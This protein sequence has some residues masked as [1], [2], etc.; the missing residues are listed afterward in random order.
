[1]L[2]GNANTCKY[3]AIQPAAIA[4]SI[5]GNVFPQLLVHN[6]PNGSHNNINGVLITLTSLRMNVSDWSFVLCEILTRVVITVY[7]FITISILNQTHHWEH[8]INIRTQGI[9]TRLI[10]SITWS[11][12]AVSGCSAQTSILSALFLCFMAWMWHHNTQVVP[13]NAAV[14]PTSSRELVTH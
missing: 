5:V 12:P 6:Q 3:R 4:Q 8:P 7:L 2:T 9:S 14:F 11:I 10:C 13:D 1:M